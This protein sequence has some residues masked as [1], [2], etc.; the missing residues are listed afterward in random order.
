MAGAK[1]AGTLFRVL[2][3][4]AGGHAAILHADFERDGPARTLL[5]AGRSGEP[6]THAIADGIVNHHGDD[7]Q[8]PHLP[9]LLSV[10]GSLMEW[11]VITAMMQ[12]IATMDTIGRALSI[13]FRGLCPDADHQLGQSDRRR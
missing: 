4:K 13:Q 11:A 5:Q 2:M 1:A 9:Q 10:L 8:R 3:A 7:Q 12:Q 6:V